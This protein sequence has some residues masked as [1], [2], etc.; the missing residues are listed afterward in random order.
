MPQEIVPSL[1]VVPVVGLHDDGGCGP[2]LGTGSFVGDQKVLIT[3]EHVLAQWQGAYGISAQEDELRLY[4]AE[5]L[6]RE[7]ASD[8]ACLRVS[9]YEPPYSFPLADDEEIILNEFVCAFEYGTTE[10]AGGHINFTPANRMGNVTRVLDLTDQFDRA[11]DR[12]LELSFPALRGASGA[13]IVLWHPPFKLWGIITANYAR[14]L[15]PAHV[16]RILEENGQISEETNFYL[17]QAL[18]IHVSHVRA[19]LE[20][21]ITPES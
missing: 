16:E 13:A 6:I 11:G 19:V 14:E 2:F 15:L 7:P 1:C 12:M 8:L 17:P 5:P 10:V 21:L 18:G 9:T 4:P 20:R 3:C